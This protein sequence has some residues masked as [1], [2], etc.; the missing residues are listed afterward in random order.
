[1]SDDGEKMNKAERL[2]VAGAVAPYV[3]EAAER[4][5]QRRVALYNQ[6]SPGQETTR[7]ASL[8]DVQK[9]VLERAKIEIEVQPDVKRPKRTICTKCGKLAK[10]AY[11]V[12]RVP[13]LCDACRGDSCQDCGVRL[14]VHR[15]GRCPD[16]AAK[17]K[18]LCSTLCSTC[19]KSTVSPRGICSDCHNKPKL[20][21][22]TCVY[23]KL[24]STSVAT[25]AQGVPTCVKC[26]KNRRISH[27]LFLLQIGHTVKD[28][29]NAVRAKDATVCKWVKNAANLPNC[30]VCGGCLSAFSISRKK[31]RCKGCLR[32]KK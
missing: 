19:G 26:T 15:G 4:T 8:L 9:G 3:R 20:K 17:A 6:H 13:K 21:R 32:E 11:K 28:V 31:D 2:A 23:C 27:A 7:Y 1:M 10:P 5:S 18:T 24:C 22:Q 12:G 16:C 25:N 30:S 14:H 29:A